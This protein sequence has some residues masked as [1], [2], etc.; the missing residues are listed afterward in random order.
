[1]SEPFVPELGP[2]VQQPDGHENGRDEDQ[3]VDRQ[4]AAADV[5]GVALFLL[6]VGSVHRVCLAFA[7]ARFVEH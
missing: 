4:Y 2:Y 1:L 5:G 7:I 3:V 6:V